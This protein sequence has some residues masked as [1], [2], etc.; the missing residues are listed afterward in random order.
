MG[1]GMLAFSL[2]PGPVNL[3]LTFPCLSDAKLRCPGHSQPEST[4]SSSPGALSHFP[5]SLPLQ[6]QLT[7]P[8]RGQISCCLRPMS[9]PKRAQPCHDLGGPFPPLITHLQA[10]GTPLRAPTPHSTP[11]SRFAECLGPPCSVEAVELNPVG[12]ETPWATS[13]ISLMRKQ[14]PGGHRS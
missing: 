8:T 5:Q 2:G 4:S 12:L 1:A 6:G 11:L 7:R 3:C 13:F 10:P 9:C 14:N